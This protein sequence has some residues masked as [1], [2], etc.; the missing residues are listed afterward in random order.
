MRQYIFCKIK[1]TWFLLT[2]ESIVKNVIIDTNI[3]LEIIEK[4]EMFKLNDWILY[5]IV[6]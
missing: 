1:N 2:N 4:V 6:H 5:V 3:Y